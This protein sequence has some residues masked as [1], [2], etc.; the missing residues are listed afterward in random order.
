[1]YRR[2]VFEEAG[3]RTQSTL[4]RVRVTVK[5]KVRVRVRSQ[6]E[7]TEASPVIR[8]LLEMLRRIKLRIRPL[9]PERVNVLGKGGGRGGIMWVRYTVCF[10]RARVY[11]CMCVC[12]SLSA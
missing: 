2:A 7:L 8:N 6:N 12:A 3:G 4:V 5:V 9:R 10:V 1:M 11:V